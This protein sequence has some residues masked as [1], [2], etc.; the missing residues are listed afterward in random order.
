M[1]DDN[2]ALTTWSKALDC[3]SFSKDFSA[4]VSCWDKCLNR[5]GVYVDT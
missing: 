2:G 3:D 1:N 5:G 4:L